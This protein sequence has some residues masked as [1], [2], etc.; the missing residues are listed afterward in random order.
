M[1][2]AQVPRC[3]DAVL[4]HPT[5]ETW[6]VA[7]ADAEHDEIAWTG[8]PN[9]RARLSDCTLVRIATDDQHQ[10]AVQAW[11]DSRHDDGRR[12]RVL[13]LYGTAGERGDGR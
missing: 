13:A 5:G 1:P 2:E 4:H 12:G 8:W 10:R 9:G 6:L 7:F 11:R 3:G